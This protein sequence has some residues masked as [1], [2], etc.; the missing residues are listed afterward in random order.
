M[1]GNHEVAN[2]A[3]Y[4]GRSIPAYAGAPPAAPHDGQSVGSIPAYAGEPSWRTSP[5]RLMGV[6]P[7]VCGGTI[8]AAGQLTA[9]DGLSPRMRGN[10]GYRLT[11]RRDDVSIPAYAGELPVAPPPPPLSAVY[12]R[13]CRGTE[14]CRMRM[15]R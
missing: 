15:S 8:V 5:S 2:N 11:L 13:V 6:Y 1:R 4:A 9:P 12:P 3:G 10:P 14:S 7:R